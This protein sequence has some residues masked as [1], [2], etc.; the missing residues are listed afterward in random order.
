MSYS[1]EIQGLIPETTKSIFKRTYLCIL[2][3]F[4]ELCK[5]K[6]MPLLLTVLSGV[7]RG[8]GK[9]SEGAK[10]VSCFLVNSFRQIQ[11]D[12]LKRKRAFYR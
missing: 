4:S 11:N 10:A 6:L 7:I 3:R 9:L 8:L 12:K 2:R 1:F 5:G